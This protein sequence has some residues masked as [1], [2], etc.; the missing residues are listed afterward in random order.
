METWVMSAVALFF[1]DDGGASGGDAS[2]LRVARLLRLSR[3]ARMARLLRALP[4]LM[5]MI[6]GMI[7][8]TRSVFFTLCLLWICLYVFA[9]AFTQLTANTP[10]GNPMLS[11]NVP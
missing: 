5:I 7:A 9:I 11:S 6:R 10:I 3:M 8:A 4:E 2:L 1:V